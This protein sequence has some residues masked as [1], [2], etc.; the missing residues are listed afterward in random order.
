[1]FPHGN[2]AGQYHWAAVVHVELIRGSG[3]VADYNEALRPVDVQD[4]FLGESSSRNGNL[5]F[6]NSTIRYLDIFDLKMINV[7]V[8]SE[9]RGEP[10]F[11]IQSRL[12][13]LYRTLILSSLV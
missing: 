11:S 2:S 5:T 7:W 4:N 13:S 1:M 3:I 8:R 10:T 12:P 6:I 9:A